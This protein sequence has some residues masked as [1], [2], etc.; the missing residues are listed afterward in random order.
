MVF[1]SGGLNQMKK[2]IFIAE[3]KTQSPF[4][5]KSQKSWDELFEIADHY[6]DWISI[7]TNPLW[8]GSFELVKKARSKTTKPILAKGIH[9]DDRDARFALSLGANYVLILG[10]LPDTLPIDRI[11]VEPLNFAQYLQFDRFGEFDNRPKILFNRR[12]LSTGGTKEEDYVV[13]R[14]TTEWLCQASRI[15]NINEVRPDA[16]A[17]LVG[18]HLPLFVESL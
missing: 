15:R 9:A 7:H 10:R 11:I 4:G 6:G 18:T 1:G 17:Y 5:F 13:W 2:P 12:E 3:V 16:D 14:N 8:G